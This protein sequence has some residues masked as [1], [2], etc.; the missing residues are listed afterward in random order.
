MPARALSTGRLVRARAGARRGLLLTTTATLSVAVATVYAILASLTVAV[1]RS[2]DAAPPGVPRDEVAAQVAAGVVALLSAAPA[3]IVLV[4]LLASTAVLQLGRLLAAAR[5]QDMANL[6]AR[7]LSGRQAT[8]LGAIEA[9]AIAVTAS[10]FGLV[11]GVA[12]TVLL[13]GAQAALEALPLGWTAPLT[14]L[15]LAAVLV[16]AQRRRSDSRRRGARIATAA[17]I[18]V[19]ALTGA[20]AVWQL[21]QARPGG[22][23]PIVAIAPSAVLLAAA[24]LVLAVFAAGAAAVA[25][26]GAAGPGPALAPRQVARRL[27]V[28]AVAVLLV[29]LT[30][31][32][33][34]FAAAYSATWTAAATDSA[35]VRAGADLR[36][37]LP[38]QTASPATV[39]DAAA[40][41]GVDAA[42]GVLVAPIEIG[43]TVA[44]IIAVPSVAI[45][46]VLSP[47]GGAV[48]PEA[49]AA[50]VT[51]TPDSVAGAPVALGQEATGIRVTVEIASSRPN[52][53]A[54]FQLSATFVDAL[55]TPTS[56]RLA[57]DEVLAGTTAVTATADV[58]AGTGPW[59]LSALTAAIPPAFS[60]ADVGVRIDTV[61][62]L[63]GDAA[64][65]ALA[66]TGEAVLGESAEAVLWVGAEPGDPA[67]VRAAIGS[68][69]AARL[70]IG[71]GDGVEFRYAGTGR[72]GELEVAAVVD[73][74]PG[75][76]SGLAVFVPLDALTASALQRGTSFVPPNAVWAAGD[77]D[78]DRAFSEALGDRPVTTAAPGVTASVV[79]SLV[80]GWWIAAG[81]SGALALLAAFAIIQTLSLDRRRDLGV[82]RA[83]GLTP[84]AQARSRAGEVAAV[85]AASAVL[86]TVAGIAVS[87]LVAPALVQAVTPGILALGAGV[88]IAWPPFAIAAAL[89]LIGLSVVTGIAAVGV[90][91]AAI[92]ATVGEE[93][94]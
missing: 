27:P 15:V 21:P 16:A 85:F 13:F 63:A 52:V 62:P 22:F 93:A 61:Q 6:R 71:P 83:L 77:P 29:A 68:A 81:G 42:A 75:A 39:A 86:G 33:A 8:A 5:E 57:L 59:S 3:L 1:E 14:A 38:P 72:R 32:Q 35:A 90:R 41:E 4:L 65:E 79:G 91:R 23:D 82:L 36:V 88:A 60:T 43:S 78:A 46:T 69:L 48:D 9:A 24:L 76:Q 45:P 70:G 25:R 73:A 54:A 92:G 49:L 18:G 47:A 40:V 28:Y 87:W 11:S 7:G 94:R 84:G 2:G 66:V 74:V 44:E 89:Q 80:S 10:V 50:T 55:G 51:P 64:G 20:F 53:A 17:A 26:A 56:A 31:A 67:P 37:D 58:P 19:V 30:F 34:L 12:L